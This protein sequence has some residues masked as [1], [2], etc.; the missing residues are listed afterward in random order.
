[1]I[2]SL[3]IPG[4]LSI[5]ATFGAIYLYTSELLPTSV[6]TAALG[7]S[8]MFGRIGAIVSPYIAA[9]KIYGMW[10]PL[11]IFGVNAVISGLLILL[12][13]ETLGRDLPETVKDALKLGKESERISNN[14][15]S[16]ERDVGVI[17][18]GFLQFNNEGNYEEGEE[19]GSLSEFEDDND[20]VG[21]PC[22]DQGP[23]IS[24]G[25]I[26]S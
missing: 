24:N 17:G 9:L 14:E 15:Q 22:D 1:M 2:L 13:P 10:I 3:L 6:R 19:C 5:T 26:L 7:T 4:K 23:L 8:S 18:D 11:V 20:A 21:A 12:L 25:D 16:V